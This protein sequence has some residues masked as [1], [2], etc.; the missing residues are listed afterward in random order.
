MSTGR[1]NIKSVARLA[2]TIGL[3]KSPL[4]AW[5]YFFGPI[6][7]AA[8]FPP[9]RQKP[10]DPFSALKGNSANEGGRVAVACGIT[11]II[12]THIYRGDI[13]SE[14]VEQSGGK[15][16]GQKQ[17]VGYNYFGNY[18][19]GICRGPVHISRRWENKNLIVFENDDT[20]TLYNGTTT[21]TVD[22]DW[23][24][25]VDDLIPFR[26]LAYEVAWDHA[27]GGSNQIPPTFHEIHNIPYSDALVDGGEGTGPIVPVVKDE[28]AYGGIIAM[29]KWDEIYIAHQDEIKIYN[30]DGTLKKTIDTSVLGL[31]F[32]TSRSFR[33]V[34]TSGSNG[35]TIHLIYIDSATGQELLMVSFSDNINILISN[36]LATPFGIYGSEDNFESTTLVDDSA[37][38]DPIGLRACTNQDFIFVTY[39]QNNK[40]FLL[41]LNASGTELGNYDM[42][43]TTGTHKIQSVSASDDFVFIVDASDNDLH[44]VSFTGTVI[45]TESAVGTEFMG[46]IPG[47]QCVAIV[48]K[49]NDMTMNIFPYND[50]GTFGTVQ[51]ADFDI[52][53]MSDWSGAVPFTGTGNWQNMIFGP[54]GTMWF[55]EYQVTPSV[56][57]T[58]GLLYD[59]NPAQ[60]FY[61]NAV[62]LKKQDTSK[63][64]LDQWKD[65][66]DR[67]IDNGI[68]MSF[69]LTEKISIG[70]L[71]RNM[72]GHFGG[73]T[74]QNLSGQTEILF[75]L[76]SDTAAAGYTIEYSDIVMREIG[77]I[78]PDLSI[79]RTDNKDIE[80]APNRLNATFTNRFNDYKTEATFPV[81]D[82]LSQELDGDITDMTLSMPYFSNN[83]TAKKCVWRMYKINRF[84]TEL[85]ILK[86]IPKWLK[87]LPGDVVNINLPDYGYDNVKMRVHSIQ[88]PPLDG[89]HG[90]SPEV[91]F[92]LE[93]DWVMR[94]DDIT[95]DGSLS[96]DVSVRPA[97][98]VIPVVWE[99]NAEQNRG[100]LRLGISGIRTN[101]SVIYA[102]IYISI[103]DETNYTRFD[104]RIERFANVGD[105]E[106]KIESQET[107]LQINTDGSGFGTFS[108]FTVDEQ[109]NEAS[110]CVI[111]LRETS[112]GL[113][114]MEMISYR[115]TR[116][117]GG[118]LILENIARGKGYT[119]PDVEHDTDSI[120]LHVARTYL[121]IRVPSN[122]IGKTIY[123]KMVPGNDTGQSLT[124]SDVA[125]FPFVIN[126]YGVKST[127]VAG[128]C[129][130]DNG[131]AL[132]SRIVHSTNEALMQ[133]REISNLDGWGI[134][135]SSNQYEFGTFDA[136]DTKGYNLLVYTTVAGEAGVLTATHHDVSFTDQTTHLEYAYTEA[137]NI[138]DFSGLTKDFFLG[139][140]PRNNA[141][142][143]SDY[144][145]KRRV[146]LNT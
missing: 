25:A 23:D 110:F 11:R 131:I 129:G 26:R 98:E 55:S 40:A 33:I 80:S 22:P 89:A 107:E 78:E 125:G 119:L 117:T 15:N 4:G 64:A 52:G 105:V 69:N 2:L 116:V 145:V 94:F 67:C 87:L 76:E 106:V 108:S 99:E 39:H 66:G 72:L 60:L 38:L 96:E 19:F 46:W 143:N 137:Q 144:I 27:L 48:E 42:S 100:D 61:Y 136:S 1:E 13:R 139:L 32:S 10:P 51:P 109:R 133:W 120:I 140:Q 36:T 41:K 134:R 7:G 85:H 111:G 30:R 75:P 121:K 92:Q 114:N 83:K 8:L 73:F 118:D 90:A 127:H 128:F 103:D 115:G 93:E 17:V 77:A 104:K 49:G 28:I 146:I 12:P 95:F 138:I 6:I 63:L 79:I 124:I 70:G 82:L 86:L 113:T 34:L 122:W 71:L 54:N 97:G 91:S 56:N 112:A 43:G 47:S 130:R 132:G 24:A 45:D 37:N 135:G 126:G 102:D 31:S 50:A 81:D 9:E 21:Q 18:A 14:A 53:D 29:N 3:G 44:S 142:A 65:W 88:Q 16:L 84:V 20:L 123:I 101:T 5:G 74:R 58:W 35:T 141:G 59:A 62:T 68:G 57:S